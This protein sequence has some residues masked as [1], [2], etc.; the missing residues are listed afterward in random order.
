M[1]AILSCFPKMCCVLCHDKIVANPMQRACMH[2]SLLV[3]GGVRLAPTE[4]NMD[5][6]GNRSV[7]FFLPAGP[8]HIFA[9]WEEE[10]PCSHAHDM[11]ARL[12]PNS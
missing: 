7:S 1:P 2:R 10:L 3:V 8:S 11:D 6:K 5:P 12:Y 4:E 9:S